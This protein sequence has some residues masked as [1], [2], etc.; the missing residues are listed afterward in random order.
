MQALDEALAVE[1]RRLR[2]SRRDEIRKIGNAR[3]NFDE[4]SGLDGGGG[5]FVHQEFIHLAAEMTAVEKFLD[6]AVL[7]GYDTVRVVHGKGTGA[8]KRAVEGCLR[9]HPLVAGFRTGAPAEGG[10][11]ATVVELV[12]G[13]QP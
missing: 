2:G 13:R 11:G 9:G 12:E 6:D 4:T 7:A 1:L 3:E 5:F 8:L 10:S